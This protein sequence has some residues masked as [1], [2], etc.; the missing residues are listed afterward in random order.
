MSGLMAELLAIFWVVMMLLATLNIAAMF[1]N[2]FMAF[3]FLQRRNLKYAHV[4]SRSHYRNSLL[5][6]LGGIFTLFEIRR[7]TSFPKYG[8]KFWPGERERYSK[9]W[10]RKQLEAESSHYVKMQY[11]P[12]RTGRCRSIW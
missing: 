3:S 11:H 10:Y 8:L 6:C 9:Y 4:K 7:I 1:L 5:F 2:Y 12:G